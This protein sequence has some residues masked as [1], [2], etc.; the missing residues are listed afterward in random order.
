M[1]LYV[2]ALTDTCLQKLTIGRRTLRTVDIDG[3]YAVCESRRVAPPL[4]DDELREQH[5]LVV[6]VARRV[7]AVLP[8]RF[9]ALVEKHAL[10]TL[11]QS[12]DAA[13]RQGLEDV[14]GRVQ[15]TV[16]VVG[17]HPPRSAVR[18]STGREYLEQRRRSAFPLLPRPARSLLAAVRPLAAR[19]R[20]EP[21]AGGL[22]A[23]IYHLIDA[24][25][26]R[27][28]NR[29]AEIAANRATTVTGPWPPFAF[30][31]QLW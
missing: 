12:H 8:V 10:V 7:R 27:R 21:G 24:D 5:A 17:P 22:L 20:Q 15:M 13:I 2:I 23:T 26:V 31:P 19:E 18:A 11:V 9:G 28:Y 14:R 4:T 25:A 3:I 30:A 6:D 16:R 1:A 29:T